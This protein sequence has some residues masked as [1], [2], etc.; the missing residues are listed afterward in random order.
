MIEHDTMNKA[1]RKNIANGRQ[2]VTEREKSKLEIQF[3]SFL[4]ML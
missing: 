3:Y 4:L 1:T 2:L